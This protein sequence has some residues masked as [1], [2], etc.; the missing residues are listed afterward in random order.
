M[1]RFTI[2][3]FALLLTSAIATPMVW[4]ATHETHQPR[5]PEEAV[6]IQLSDRFHD[7]QQD[8]LND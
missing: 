6:I 4:A 1:T 5:T 7:E 2:S 8:N 3:S